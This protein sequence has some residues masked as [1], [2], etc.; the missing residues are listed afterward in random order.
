MIAESA[1]AWISG[2]HSA[3]V[4]AQHLTCVT[5]QG[6]HILQEQVLEGAQ[7]ILHSSLLIVAN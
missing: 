2:C 1:L 4:L 5:R 3:R 6:S 7:L